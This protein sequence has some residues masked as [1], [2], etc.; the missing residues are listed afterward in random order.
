MS[1][2]SVFSRGV[3]AVV[4][5]L[6]TIGIIPT[7]ASASLLPED[8]S[9][10]GSTASVV[11]PRIVGGTDT[12]KTTTPW[13]VWLFQVTDA[14][15]GT[16]YSCGGSL[17]NHRWI[18]TAAHCVTAE[19]GAVADPANFYIV[20]AK[21]DLR[22]LRP[23]DVS[24][25]DLVVRHPDY[26]NTESALQNDVALVR[27][28][29]PQL[30]TRKTKPIALPL[31]LDADVWPAHGTPVLVSGWG[32]LKTGGRAS[33]ILQSAMIRVKGDPLDDSRCGFWSL[34]DA[35]DSVQ[36]LCAGFRRNGRDICQGDSGGPYAIRNAGVWTLAGITSYNS[37]QCGRARWPGV[38]AR[39]TNFLDWFVSP[40][41][42]NVGWS[43][44][45]STATITW[46]ASGVSSATAVAGY[47]IEQSLDGGATWEFV[48]TVSA[49]TFTHAHTCSVAQSCVYRVATVDGV[50]S[51]DA[52]FRFSA[53]P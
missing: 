27:L 36:N 29:I 42:D 31:D 11:T 44:S 4:V 35:F 33:D 1:V 18:V 39:V 28:T 10:G 20:T 53:L 17:I 52:P 30:F 49:S 8:V 46:I 13:Q 43:Y 6:S 21:S 41:P 26:V 34:V 48:A 50:N 24:A 19:N 2:Y 37:G 12:D 15:A 7:T 40:A 47:R 16:G 38:A 5:V 25:V 23:A 45:G 51:S 32:A 3:A 22:S 14:D 9:G